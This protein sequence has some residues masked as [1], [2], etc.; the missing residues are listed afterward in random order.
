MRTTR[1]AELALTKGLSLGRSETHRIILES[2]S[3]LSRSGDRVGALSSNRDRIEIIANILSTLFIY[4]LPPS[5]SSSSERS[6]RNRKP[7][8]PRYPAI[9]SWNEIQAIRATYP[10]MDLRRKN[11]AGRFMPGIKWNMGKVSSRDVGGIASSLPWSR[12]IAK[13]SSITR[14]RYFK[15]P[16][17]FFYSSMRGNGQILND[18]FRSFFY[19]SIEWREDRNH[20]DFHRK[21][22]KQFLYVW[23]RDVLGYLVI[24]DSS[25]RDN[26]VANKFPRKE[27]LRINFIKNKLRINKDKL[28][29][30]KWF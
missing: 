2:P 21:F 19:S 24:L 25:S 26:I 14:I 17:L 13:N 10:L 12:G 22:L 5:F 9:W 6:A 11:P 7:G 18:C 20:L 16:L 3:Q 8:I 29:R 4:F 30:S 28:S 1:R 15:S 27:K 23:C